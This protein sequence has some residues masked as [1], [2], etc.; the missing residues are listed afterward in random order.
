MHKHNDV[1]NLYLHSYMK[2]RKNVDVD[3]RCIINN[4]NN[5]NILVYVNH[6]K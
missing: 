5:D 3:G 6:E 4:Y 1:T 2:L